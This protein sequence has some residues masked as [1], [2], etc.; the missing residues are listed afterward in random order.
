MVFRQ[1][2]LFLHRPEAVEPTWGDC[3]RTCIANILE[4]APEVLPHTHANMSGESFKTQMDAFLVT[5]GL[6]SLQMWWPRPIAYVLDVHREL[7]PDIFYIL[8]GFTHRGVAHSV[9]CHAGAIF[10]NPSRDPGNDIITP[11]PD[12]NFQTTYIVLDRPHFQSEEDFIAVVRTWKIND[13]IYPKASSSPVLSCRWAGLK[14]C[15]DLP[16]HQLT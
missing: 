13:I 4:L 15:R 3:H 11:D 6:T 9:L 10:H 7:N 8:S 12:G 1:T 2:Q 14:L 5:H 16:D